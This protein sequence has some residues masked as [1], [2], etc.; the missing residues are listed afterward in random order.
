MTV[1]DD[2][3]KASAQFN[4]TV[5]TNMVSDVQAGMCKVRAAQG[6]GHMCAT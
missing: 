4:T 1:A 2:L 6:M 3:I 5:F